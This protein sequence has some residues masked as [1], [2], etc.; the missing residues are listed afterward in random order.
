M[1][2]RDLKKLIANFVQKPAYATKFFYEKIKSTWTEPTFQSIWTGPQLERNQKT[3]TAL[4]QSIYEEKTGYQ[5]L[6]LMG[7]IFL[8]TIYLLVAAF[9]LHRLFWSREGLRPFSLYPYIF[10]LGGFFFHIFWETKSQYVYVYLLLLLPVAARA[11]NW[12]SN[13]RPKKSTHK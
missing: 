13:W 6:N 10:F 4:L 2:S 11:L 8:A 9:I 12:L 7:M 5:L 3:K 1:A